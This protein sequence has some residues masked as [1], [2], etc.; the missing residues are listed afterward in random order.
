MK[1]I[2]FY[3]DHQT[4]PQRTA[5]FRLRVLHG[6]GKN[7]VELKAIYFKERKEAERFKKYFRGVIDAIDRRNIDASH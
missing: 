1:N 6:T 4:D 7:R 2:R 3:I 5:K